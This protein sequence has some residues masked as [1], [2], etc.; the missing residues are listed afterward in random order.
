[1]VNH[2]GL[3]AIKPRLQQVLD[4]PAELLVRRGIHPDVV[5]YSGVACGVLG[6]T[7]LLAGALWLVPLLALARLTFNALD[8]MVAVRSGLARPWGKVLNEFCDRLADV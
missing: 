8:G 7:A 2:A 4:G 6:G 3:Y 5:T 1:M